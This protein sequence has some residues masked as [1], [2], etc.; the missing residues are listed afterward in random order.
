MLMHSWELVSWSLPNPQEWDP[1]GSSG[2]FPPEYR[3]GVVFFHRSLPSTS[4]PPIFSWATSNP[5]E[6]ISTTR[7]GYQLQKPPPVIHSGPR[8]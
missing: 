5:P 4:H 1:L 7:G 6:Q 2:G 3:G 8:K